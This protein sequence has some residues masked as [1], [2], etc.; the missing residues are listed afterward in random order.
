M[1]GKTFNGWELADRLGGWHVYVRQD[2][3]TKQWSYSLLRMPE[4]TALAGPGPGANPVGGFESKQAALDAARTE[5][6]H[7]EQ[8]RKGGETR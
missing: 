2:Q 8:Q 5:L 6:A 7:R 1:A 3:K 4:R